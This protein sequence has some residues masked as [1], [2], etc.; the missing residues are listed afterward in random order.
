MGQGVLLE[1][2]DHG[3]EVG[4]VDVVVDVA[5][6]IRNAGVFWTE[7]PLAIYYELVLM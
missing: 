5:I 2:V 4:G 6:G 1:G 3:V 7:P